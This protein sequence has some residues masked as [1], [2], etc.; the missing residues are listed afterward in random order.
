MNDPIRN[1]TILVVDDVPANIQVVNAILKDIYKVRIATTGVK[2]LELAI[3]APPP[4]LILLDL[5]M[6]VIS[7]KRFISREIS[8]GD[9]HFG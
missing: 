6:P 3:R 8:L 1:K 2:A 9:I 5:M 4:D 7:K